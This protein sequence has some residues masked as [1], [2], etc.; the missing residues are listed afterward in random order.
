MEKMNWKLYWGLKVKKL[1][2]LLELICA[3]TNKTTIKST[4]GL[5]TVSN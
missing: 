4:V 1:T 2:S 5:L 3:E